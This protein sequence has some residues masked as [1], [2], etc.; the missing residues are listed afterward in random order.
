MKAMNL[1]RLQM[2]HCPIKMEK[3]NKKTDIKQLR[4]LKQSI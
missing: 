1:S 3:S 2:K 4:V